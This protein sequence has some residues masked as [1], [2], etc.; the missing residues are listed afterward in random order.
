M[1]LSLEKIKSYSIQEL[2][3][4]LN[5]IL[6]KVKTNYI[7]LELDQFICQEIMSVSL[8]EI[9][10]KIDDFQVDT[11]DVIL[12]QK[13]KEG[14]NDYICE[15]LTDVDK[16]NLIIS[17]YI[18]LNIKDRKGYKETLK[19]FKK[20]SAFFESINF[21]PTPDLYIE[22]LKN[23]LINR[24][25]KKIVDVNLNIIS[26]NEIE[27]IFKDDF[28]ISLI[29]TY[30][31]V[32]DIKIEEK[33]D[34]FYDDFD[35]SREIYEAEYTLDSV[36]TYLLEIN[37]PLLRPE[38]EKELAYRVLQGDAKARN[39]FI[40]RNL[41]LVVNIAKKYIGRGL[42]FMDLIQEGNLGLMTAV[43]RFDVTRGYKLSTYATHWI[44]QAI[45]RAI[46]DKGRNV[47][48]PVHL[49][50]KIGKFRRTQSILQKK[51]NREPKTEEIAD[52]MGISVGEVTKL[53]KLQ[54]DTVSINSL[55][56][57]EED[58]KLENFIPSSE[59]TPEDVYV[60][61]SLQTNV[62]EL[63]KKCNL[64]EKE[65]QILM[66]R[67]GFD[68]CEP[69]TLEQIGKKLGVT[70]ERVRQIEAKAIMKIRRSRYIKE[71]AIYMTSPAEALENIETYREIYRDKKNKTKKI[72]DSK[73]AKKE[74]TTLA[75][76]IKKE[77]PSKQEERNVEEMRK[78]LQTI[79]EYLKG[80]TREEINVMLSKLSD[81]EMSLVRLRYGEDLD[82]PVTLSPWGKEQTDKFYGSL[83]PK[84]KR[85]LSNPD[86]KRKKYTRRLKVEQDSKPSEVQQPSNIVL[87]SEPEEKEVVTPQ[88]ITPEEPTIEVSQPNT[89]EIEREDCVRILE[90]MRTPSFGEMLKAL[91]PKEAVIICLKLGYVDGKYFTTE[92]IAGFLGIEKEEVIETTKK[93]LLLYKENINQFIDKAVEV[94]TGSSLVLKK[95]EN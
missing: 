12:V 66:L 73:T 92:S 59:Q 31:M 25:V 80:Y 21:F 36:K 53:Y 61:S 58:S 28:S 46:A 17:N 90:L 37:K 6:E 95:K 68:D 54:V 64:K 40:E 69:Q 13:L 60:D 83:I 89:S 50:E 30:C 87:N 3:N 71:F 8:E 51:L 62:R 26:S 39:L 43:D 85:L 18:K 44:R 76:G 11:F 38:E 94:T 16:F 24:I 91:T 7:Y 29:E 14:I 41:K 56:G 65:I 1:K 70:R 52:E 78:Q 49:Y 48:V 79:Y 67:Y 63:L 2:C 33:E 57:D 88:L 32:N 55:I 86:G 9:L 5:P 47:R 23:S 35:D 20:L 22:L 15:Q 74:E 82:N 75:V 42:Q 10:K 93:V 34:A 81:E 77:I 72:D 4:I 27:K 84:M 45:T 19:E